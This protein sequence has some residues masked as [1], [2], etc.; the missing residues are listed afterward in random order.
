MDHL[1]ARDEDL[2]IPVPYL[3]DIEYDG[4]EFFTYGHR[5]GW[6]FIKLWNCDL[7]G[8]TV[9]QAARF[10]QTWLYFGLLHVVFGRAVGIKN[11]DFIEE[12]DGVRLITTKNLPIYVLTWKTYEQ[13]RTTEEKQARFRQVKEFLQRYIGLTVRWCRPSIEQQLR[14]QTRWPLSPEICLSVIILGD[15]I[16]KAGFEI[17]RQRFDLNWGD[18]DLLKFRMRDAGWCPRAVATLCKGQ[19]IHNLWYASTLGRPPVQQPHAGCDERLCDWEQVD[20]TTYR[21]QHRAPCTDCNFLGPET[22]ALVQVIAIEETPVVAYDAS[23]QKNPF[24]S[25]STKVISEYVAISHVCKSL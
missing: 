10:L 17:L 19:Q 21:T 18:S 13:S 22:D 12:V 6:D 23:N 20:Q 7:E 2:R 11:S 1:P 3:S 25:S 16:V 15:T 14:N 5:V 8:K 4:G 9:A 24:M